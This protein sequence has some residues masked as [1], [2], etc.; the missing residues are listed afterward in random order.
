MEAVL[1]SR[2]K[3]KR[4]GTTHER[5]IEIPHAVGGFG[6]V[7]VVELRRAEQRLGEQRREA[8][9]LDVDDAVDQRVRQHRRGQ[10][11]RRHELDVRTKVGPLPEETVVEVWGKKK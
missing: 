4:E 5:P 10:R 6:D 7:V 9:H 3:G 11:E 8:E 1:T 2:A